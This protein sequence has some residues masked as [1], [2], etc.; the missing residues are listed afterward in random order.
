MPT[1][2]I[3]DA[4]ENDFSEKVLEASRQHPVLVDFWADWCPPCRVLT[5][6]LEKVTQALNGKI[7]LAKVEVDDNM[8]LAGRYQLRGFPTVILFVN[9]VETGRFSGARREPQVQEFIS[10]HAPAAL[11]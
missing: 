1:S 5:P 8:H 2:L 6:V 7:L 3:F 4:T 10:Q 11:L 9:G